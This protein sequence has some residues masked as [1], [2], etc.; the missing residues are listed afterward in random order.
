M[1]SVS[2]AAAAAASRRGI[3]SAGTRAAVV[4]FGGQE[5][6]GA[7][8]RLAL[9][10]VAAT[11]VRCN[12]TDSPFR[13]IKGNFVMRKRHYNETVVMGDV[14][15]L[16]ETA[17][18]MLMQQSKEFP[19]A[20]WEVFAKRCLQS[21]HMLNATEMALVA[22]TFDAHSPVLR[23]RFDVYRPIAMRVATLKERFPGM[24]VLALAEI[25]PRRLPTDDD[26]DVAGLLRTLGRH[27]VGALWELKPAHA[28]RVLEAVSE[29]GVKDASLT[30]R[31]AKKVHAQLGQEGVASPLSL[32]E[33]ASVGA[34]MANQDHRDLDLFMTLADASTQLCED[35]LARGTGVHEAAESMKSLLASFEKLGIDAVPDQMRA[36]A[37]EVASEAGRTP[38][39]GEIAAKQKGGMAD[40]LDP[41]PSTSAGAAGDERGF[42]VEDAAP[43]RQTPPSR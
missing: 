26:Q 36:A 10:G 25:L 19:R 32:P 14:R 18:E 2:M 30:C 41:P 33:L 4:A 8:L 35:A 22:R 6:G 39:Q 11:Q 15:K 20:F 9:Q 28:V 1:A 43:P 29:Q 3:G 21:M 42:A 5:C 40:M 23:Q 16:M 38:H 31:V 7:R 34:T 17:Q 13:H 12:T 24:A 27:A 37:A